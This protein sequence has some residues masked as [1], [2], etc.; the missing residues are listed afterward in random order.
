MA[1]SCQ[2]S[3]LSIPHIICAAPLGSVGEPNFGPPTPPL[4]SSRRVSVR[5][6]LEF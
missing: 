5:V 2:T 6:S 4:A 1:V 3:Y